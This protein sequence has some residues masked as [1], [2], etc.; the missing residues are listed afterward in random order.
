MEEQKEGIAV[1]YAGFWIRLVAYIIDWIVI[2]IISAILGGIFWM[3]TF[4]IWA[5][6]APW[7]EV[8]RPFW[9]MNFPTWPLA[10]AYF[11]CFWARRGETPGM[12]AL[13]IRVVHADGTLLKWD[14][15]AALLRFLG[16]IIC[17][18]TLG[19]LFLW[20]AFDSRKQGIHDKFADTYVVKLPPKRVVLPGTQER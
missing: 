5:L 13:K 17:W 16:Y 18:I 14:W 20:V 6:G 12:M 11:I 19:L 2:W 15:G 4:P 10:A 7:D 1:E 8:T 9:L 3:F